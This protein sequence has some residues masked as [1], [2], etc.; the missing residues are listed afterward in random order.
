MS[1]GRARQ[2]LSLAYIVNAYGQPGRV[3]RVE[4]SFGPCVLGGVGWRNCN[5]VVVRYSALAIEQHI[6]IFGH[7]NDGLDGRPLAPTMEFP[8]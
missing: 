6:A 4:H 7:A 1:G 8:F 3:D 5:S 2:V